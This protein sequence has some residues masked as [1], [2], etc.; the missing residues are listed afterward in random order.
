MD[1]NSDFEKLDAQFAE[2]KKHGY[3]LQAKGVNL[4][5]FAESGSSNV[6]IYSSLY[7]ASIELAKNDP[8]LQQKLTHFAASGFSAAQTLANTN[9]SLRQT[10]SNIEA[11]I[12]QP[13]AGVTFSNIA[14]R[15]VAEHAMTIA[16]KEQKK[17]F[18]ELSKKCLSMPFSIGELDAMLLRFREDLPSRRAGAWDA[19]HS[20]S[21]DATAQASHTMRDILA[22]IIA[23]E[24]DN[25]AIELCAW[26]IERKK[27]QPETK[28]NISDRIRFLLFGPSNQKIDEVELGI[29]THAVSEYV[30][31]DGALKKTAHGSQEFTRDQIKLSLEKIEELLYLVLKR[32]EDHKPA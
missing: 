26:Y 19:F 29:A 10:N 3:D 25:K 22:T 18:G 13:L 23:R 20:V 15:D 2:L 11:L 32:I 27:V 30:D 16:P 6:A 24:A 17:I 14:A 5:K 21:A 7:S 12:V 4:V 28:P 31:D 1:Q 8:A 9:E